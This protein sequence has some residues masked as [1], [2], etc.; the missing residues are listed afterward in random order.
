G[1]ACV[2]S[3]EDAGTAKRDSSIPFNHQSHGGWFPPSKIQST[4]PEI[5]NKSK[6]RRI[7]YSKPR[8]S[9]RRRTAF[10][11]RLRSFGLVSDFEL[12]ISDLFGLDPNLCVP[13]CP[14][15]QQTHPSR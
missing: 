5:R 14:V 4:K 6:I 1:M 15:V 10:N 3:S 11:S 13:E 12:R 2:E 8:R 9:Q 7:K